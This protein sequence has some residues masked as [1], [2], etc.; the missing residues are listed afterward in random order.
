M[1]AA[2]SLFQ[3]FGGLEL[4]LAP[5]DF[6]TGLAPL[7][8][9]RSTMAALFAAAINAELGE[10]W[11]K[12]FGSA[13]NAAGLP[14]THPLYDK[15]PVE[16][17]LELEPSPQVV[18]QYVAAWPLLALHRAG[19]GTYEQHTLSHD[20]LTQPWQLHYILTPLDV[21]D[22]RKF[23]AA[24]VAVAKVVRLVVRQRG[25][26]AYQS[27]AVAFE[28]CGPLASVELKSHEG[29]GQAAFAGDDSGLLYYAITMNLETVELSSD[30]DDVYPPF[31]GG[32]LEV[33]VGGDGGVMPG[34][35]YA[36]SSV[37][38]QRG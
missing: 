12:L 3:G 7:D 24:C 21:G 28:P 14:S 20:R 2:N 35:I 27:G 15:S 23:E 18:R 33:G 5:A 17:V 29:P 25:H 31:D 34:L 36:D 32:M 37:P 22:W 26:L 19:T 6:S 1:T 11:D 13:T 16:T 9:A 38:V 30:R 4:P 10:A 8:P